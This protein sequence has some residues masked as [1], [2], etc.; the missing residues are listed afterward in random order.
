MPHRRSAARVTIAERARQLRCRCTQVDLKLSRRMKCQFVFTARS[1]Q[2]PRRVPVVPLVEVEER[3]IQEQRRIHEVEREPVAP[4]L[5]VGALEV[6]EIVRLESRRYPV[7]RRLKAR[8]AAAH[9]A[10]RD[11]LRVAA[12]RRARGIQLQM[13]RP[14]AGNSARDRSASRESPR[15]AADA[16]RV[17]RAGELEPAIGEAM[18]EVRGRNVR[19]AIEQIARPA[20]VPAIDAGEN[21]ADAALAL[22]EDPA[23]RARPRSWSWA[24]ASG[25]AGRRRAASRRRA[26]RSTCRSKAAP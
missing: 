16:A 23:A 11:L 18:P 19:V 9:L 15:C 20:V 26:H 21:D 13:R 6:A 4:V 25:R 5:Q 24:R 7:V 1:M 14:A 3:R 8:D 12:E 22:R 10:E 2:Q 17:D